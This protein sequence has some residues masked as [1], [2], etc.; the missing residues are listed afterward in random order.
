MGQVK[1]N[2]YEMA[3]AE[4]NAAGGVDGRPLEL[5]IR[6]TGGEPR[7]AAA[8]AEQLLSAGGVRLLAGEC[9][10]ACAA[11][12]AAVAQRYGVPYL[13]DTADDDA[14]TQQGWSYVFR[15]CQTAGLSVTTLTVFLAEVVRPRNLAVVYED[16]DLGASAARALR[17]WCWT[18]GVPL[19]LSQSFRSAASDFAPVVAAMGRARADAAVLVSSSPSDAALLIRR[20]KDEGPPPVL[21]AGVG[22]GFSES[23]FLAAAGDAAENLFTVSGWAAGAGFPGAAEFA[24][25]YRARYGQEPT[26]EAAQAYACV[27]VIA[28]ALT[29]AA[30]DDPAR[31]SQALARTE[32]VTVVGPVRFEKFGKYLNQ[33]R[34]VGLVLQVQ[35]GR[36]Q[37][38][39]PPEA[40]KSEPRLSP[41]GG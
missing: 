34:P 36:P 38:V 39:W 7:T 6:D 19:A 9:S 33:N 10:S 27:T 28:D 29:R 2:G 15:L 13:V 16:T 26:S 5:V 41:R 22:P 14:L 35:N 31:L 20:A 32:T 18:A 30:S 17:G 1:R 23:S 24:E 11:A 37:I 40:A 12:V 25:T 4:I 8:V 21:L 3:V